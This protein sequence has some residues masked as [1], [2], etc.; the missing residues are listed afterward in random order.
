[1]RHVQS[2]CNFGKFHTL[3][4]HTHKKNASIFACQR[5][6]NIHIKFFFI[7]YA[8]HWVFIAVCCLY[9]GLKINAHMYIYVWHCYC[10]RITEQVE[11]SQHVCCRIFFWWIYISRKSYQFDGFD[12]CVRFTAIRVIKPIN[13]VNENR[14]GIRIKTTYLIIKCWW[15]VYRLLINIWLQCIFVWIICVYVPSSKR[16]KKSVTI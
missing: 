11:G 9:F 14:A 8:H 4:T 16:M 2:I 6:I 1:M 10:Y 13:F 15:F 7:Y 3:H 12:A 5:L